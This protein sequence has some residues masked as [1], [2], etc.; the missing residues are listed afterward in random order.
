MILMNSTRP[1]S[2]RDT[3]PT[4][5]Q[6]ARPKPPIRGMTTVPLGIG[7]NYGSWFACVT[8]AIGEPSIR[9]QFK[10]DTGWDVDSVLMRTPIEKMVDKATGYEMMLMLKF[11]DWVTINI[12]GVEDGTQ[13]NRVEG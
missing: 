2:S 10:L 12:W 4:A 13:G 8:H 7:D 6:S 1:L 11:F 3:L 9:A 5:S